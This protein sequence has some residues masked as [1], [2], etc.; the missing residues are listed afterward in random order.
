M[1]SRKDIAQP[2]RFAELVEL[3]A[4]LRGPTGCPWDREQDHRSLRPCL[5]EETH[6][7]LEAIDRGD[8][9]A[10]R[11]ELGDLLLQVLFHAQLAAEAGRFDIN[12]VLASLHDKLVTRH[13]HV[14][15]DRSLDTAEEVL[16]QWDEIKQEQAGQDWRGDTDVGRTLPALARAQKALRRACRLGRRATAEQ[17]RAQ[18]DRALQALA[19]RSGGAGGVEGR[20]GEVL[21]SAVALAA[22]LGVDAEQALRARVERFLRE[23]PAGPDAEPELGEGMGNA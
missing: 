23:L 1:P 7:V 12:D 20:V 11:E 2:S 6:E 10:L 15:G 21:L 18:L 3:M 14:F 13:P 4:R 16:Q 22:A 8:P 19:G 9:E 17:A 5:L